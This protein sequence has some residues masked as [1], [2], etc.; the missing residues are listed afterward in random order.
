MIAVNN[1]SAGTWV[2]KAFVDVPVQVNNQE[3]QVI[4]TRAIGISFSY[5][6]GISPGQYE[7]TVY[8]LLEFQA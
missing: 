8:Y 6:N 3:G 5:V 2:T 7:G 4:P 1:V